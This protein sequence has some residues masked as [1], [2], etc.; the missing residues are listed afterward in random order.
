M[1]KYKVV[2]SGLIYPMTMLHWFWR[3][4]ERRKDVELFVI[5]PFFGNWIPWNYGMYLP[6]KY[7]KQP[8]L[9]LPQEMAN[10]HVHPQM[11]IDRIPQDI[12]L[13]MQ[14]DAGWH[15]SARPPAKCVVH[16]QTDPHV[17]KT[18]YVLPKTYSDFVFCM[19]K[20]YM[21]VG[22]IYLPY[23][24]DPEIYYP[25]DVDKIYD[26]CLIGLHYPQRDMLV[27]SIRNCG[28]KVQYSIGEIYEDNAALY[29]QSKLSLSWSS[30]EDLPARVWEG[31]G[32][33]LP[34]LTNRVPDLDNF[35][36]DGTD[37]LG[38]SSINEA[39][40]KANWA[41]KNYD[42]AVQ[43]GLS[44]YSKVKDNHTWDNRINFIFET[45]GLL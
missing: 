19:Q 32:M 40:E 8:N 41:L 7:I 39:I 3:A 26:A 21:S 18:K 35:F 9:P 4:L 20:N 27:N 28:H 36:I 13:W 31:M 25:E 23:G 6:E 5:G 1:T 22:E 2:L 44:A 14:V 15:L 38:F 17:L 16:V 37:Y 45:V 10:V 33:G 24:F 30:L 34:V 11:I 42:E 12:N 43:I 29:Q